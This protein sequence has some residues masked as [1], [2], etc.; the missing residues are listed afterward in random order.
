MISKQK[1]PSAMGNFGKGDV[2][3]H[4]FDYITMS[5]NGTRVT[6]KTRVTYALMLLPSN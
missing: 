6:T 4:Y 2:A 1:L 3:L 5:Q